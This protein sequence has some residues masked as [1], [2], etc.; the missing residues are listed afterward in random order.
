MCSR[1]SAREDRLLKVIVRFSY[2]LNRAFA[3]LTRTD[4]AHFMNDHLPNVDRIMKSLQ[5]KGVISVEI[6]EHRGELR[7]SLNKHYQDWQVDQTLKRDA[8]F[9]TKVVRKMFG[10]ARASDNPTYQID[11]LTYQSDNQTYRTDKPEVINLI[12]STHFKIR[13]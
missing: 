10:N 8:E 2:G 5:A 11:N 13:E 3:L 1:F 7:L 12:T 6:G 4:L 9:F